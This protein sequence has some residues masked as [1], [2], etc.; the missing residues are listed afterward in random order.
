M[1]TVLSITPLGAQ[2]EHA[3]RPLARDGEA[4]CKRG[5]IIYRYRSETLLR[6]IRYVAGLTQNKTSQC[7]RSF[8]L[9][10]RL[11]PKQRRNTMKNTY[12]G[13]TLK[14]LRDFSKLNCGL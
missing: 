8:L 13:A 4:Y 6:N 12:K 3:I 10:L 9:C 7:H 14:G 11:V 1:P 5:V 2:Y